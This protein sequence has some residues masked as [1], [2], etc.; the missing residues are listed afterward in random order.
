MK[1]LLDYQSRAI[2]LTD[3]RLAH[4][5]QHPEMAGLEAAID[6]TVAAPDCVIQSRT[7]PEVRLYHRWVAGTAVGDKYVCVVVKFGEA[8]AFVIT[9]YVTNSIKTGIQLWPSDA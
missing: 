5:L 8:D 4:I 9:A 2:R 3:E 7:D 1:L 6:E